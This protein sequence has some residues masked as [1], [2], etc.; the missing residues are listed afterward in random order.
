MLIPTIVMGLLAIIL[1]VMGYYKGQGQHIS[2]VKSGLNMGVEILPLLIS[3]FIVAGLIGQGAR[4][5]YFPISRR[6]WESPWCAVESSTWCSQLSTWG[7]SNGGHTTNLFL[8]R[9]I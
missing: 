6:P 2:G 9:P 3:A 5:G 4:S 8:Q 7:E 1:V